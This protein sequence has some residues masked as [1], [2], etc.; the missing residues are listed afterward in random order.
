M[1]LALRGGPRGWLNNAAQWRAGERLATLRH[2]ALL[3]VFFVFYGILSK[4]LNALRLD[5]A[6]C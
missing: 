3:N 6:L 5:D 2:G 1:R 4:E